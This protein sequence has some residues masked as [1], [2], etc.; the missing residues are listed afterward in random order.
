MNDEE[1]QVKLT[2]EQFAVLRQG[3]TEAPFSGEYNSNQ[4]DGSYMCAGC[5]TVLFHS[6]AKYDSG[7]GWPSFTQAAEEGAIDES[8]DANHGMTRTEILC[9]NCGGHLGHVFPDGPGP[10]GMRYCVNSASLE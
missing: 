10:N 3:A 7:S 8:V 6:D 2:S 4:A 9:K 5:G 1:W